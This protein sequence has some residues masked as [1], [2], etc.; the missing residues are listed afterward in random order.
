VAEASELQAGAKAQARRNRARPQNLGSLPTASG[1]IARAAYA[2]VLGAQIDVEP[3]LKLSGLTTAQVENPQA[4]IP[5][6]AQVA[7]LDEASAALGDDLLGF[8]LAQIVDLREL[9]LLYYVLASSEDLSTALRRLTRFSAILNE[10]VRITDHESHTD[11][12]AI[13]FDYVDVK[14]AHDRHQMEFFVTILLRLCRELTRRQLRPIEISLKHRRSLVSA[15]IK[16]FFNCKIEF[17][18]RFDRI[19]FQVAEKTITIVNADSYLNKLLIEYCEEIL[20][21]RRKKSGL[22]RTKVENAVAPLLPHGEANIEEVAKRLGISR[23]TLTR[24]LA[25]ETV[26]FAEILSELRLGLARKY[27]AEPEIQVAE[28]AWL[29]GYKSTGAF[30]HAFRRWTGVSPSGRHTG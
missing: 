24:R 17:G 2:K 5:V 29:L 3:L 27:L 14:R 26:S 10:G 30:S 11:A 4:R 9:G 1:G 25:A 22:W 8:E 6:R 21:T 16:A 15:R 7:F 19:V 23:R 13:T 12:F 28:V 18:S 20:A